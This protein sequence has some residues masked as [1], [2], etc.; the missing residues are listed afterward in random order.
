MTDEIIYYDVD[1]VNNNTVYDAPLEFN[2]TRNSPYIERPADYE[3]SIV[4]FEISN[5]SRLPVF[6]PKI[7]PNQ[8]DINKTVYQVQIKSSDNYFKSQVINLQYVAQKQAPIQLPLSPVGSLQENSSYYHVY[9]YDNFTIMLN[10][11]LQYAFSQAIVNY[12]IPSGFTANDLYAPF[13]T[14]N[15]DTKK[16]T[17]YA[18]KILFDFNTNVNAL[19]IFLNIPLAG[20]MN[21]FFLLDYGEDR[22][23]TIH[24]LSFSIY[25]DTRFQKNIVVQL[26][27][28]TSPRVNKALDFCVV[29]SQDLDI[30]AFNP[31][32]SLVFT[33]NIL[34]VV[35]TNTSSTANL[36]NNSGSNANISSVISDFQVNIDASS[37]YRQSVLYQPSVYRMFSLNNSGPIN[38][39]DIKCMWKNCYGQMTPLMIPPNSFANLKIMFRKKDKSS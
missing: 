12:P 11:A 13:F 37:G 32:S 14:F 39:I 33:S 4:R 2:E 27:N 23:T 24:P 20:L 3:M 21:S 30:V 18:Q 8:A 19:I 17:L 6:V 36:V 34:P 10:N 28:I 35:Y 22:N 29:E 38:S 9:N 5:T 31:V 25:F 1:I 26:N 7:A 15:R 16:Y